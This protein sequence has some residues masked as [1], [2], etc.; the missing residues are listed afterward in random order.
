MNNK[1]NN[2]SDLAVKLA[3]SHLATAKA[4]REFAERVNLKYVFSVMAVAHRLYADTHQ[5]VLFNRNSLVLD[6]VPWNLS[7]ATAYRLVEDF[8]KAGFISENPDG[9]IEATELFLRE[10]ETLVIKAMVL[11]QTFGSDSYQGQVHA[12]DFW[13]LRDSERRIINSGGLFE[14]LGF[15]DEEKLGTR[16]GALTDSETM[17]AAFGSSLDEKIVEQHYAALWSNSPMQ[18]TDFPWAMLHKDGSTVFT[19]MTIRATTLDGVM[20]AFT[21]C[22]VI[23][24]SSWRARI[25][26]LRDHIED[27]GEQCSYQ[28]LMSAS[29]VYK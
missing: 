22:R 25:Q 10:Y 8:A 6:L 4:Q 1:S 17:N 24:E 19:L 14:T 18:I 20:N 23:S 11:R 16:P 21:F 13:I 9:R 3:R 29:T 12:P 15:D 27:C 2:T 26:G 7:Q 28:T 5:N